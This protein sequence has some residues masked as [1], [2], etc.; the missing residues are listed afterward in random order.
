MAAFQT[1]NSLKKPWRWLG[2]L[3]DEAFHQA[4]EQQRT[5][6]GPDD[7]WQASRYCLA[8]L[9]GSNM[10]TVLIVGVDTN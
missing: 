5:V 10:P 9:C 6:A 3:L 2:V 8:E 4:V 1:R 7:L